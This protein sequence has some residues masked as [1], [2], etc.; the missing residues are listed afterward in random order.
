VSDTWAVIVVG[1]LEHDVVD[2]DL[3]HFVSELDDAST[4]RAC[5]I[6]GDLAGDERTVLELALMLAIE[7]ELVAVAKRRTVQPPRRSATAHACEHKRIKTRKRTLALLS[8]CADRRHA[9]Q[10]CALVDSLGQ[11]KSVPNP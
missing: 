2:I 7:E 3:I 8:L 10:N 5:K 11:T 9:S 6:L 1:A 4:A